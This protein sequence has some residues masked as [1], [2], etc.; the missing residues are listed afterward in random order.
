MIKDNIRFEELKAEK[1]TFKRG[2]Y[3]MKKETAKMFKETKIE[4]RIEFEKEVQK[5]LIAYNRTEI[6][7]DREIE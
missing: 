3:S 5:A 4:D 6:D 2:D 7:I 1:P